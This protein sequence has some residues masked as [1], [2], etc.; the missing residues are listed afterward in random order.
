MFLCFLFDKWRDGRARFKGRYRDDNNF[1]VFLLNHSDF[2]GDGNFLYVKSRGDLA[3]VFGGKV[4]GLC[5]ED[6]GNG[7]KAAG[8]YY[9]N[10]Q[11]HIMYTYYYA[12]PLKIRAASSYHKVLYRRFF[13]HLLWKLTGRDRFLV[14]G[15][16]VV[17]TKA[18]NLGCY[19]R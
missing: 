7:A 6:R 4:A 18:Q 11:P 9:D 12:L 19:I 10:M 13:I 3:F 8:P 16:H 5:S 17:L 2:H 14:K 15:P 1:L